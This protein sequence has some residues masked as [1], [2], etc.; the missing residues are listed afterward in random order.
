[1]QATAISLIIPCH[2]EENNVINL[3]NDITKIMKEIGSNYEVIYIDDGS[4]DKTLS[5][6]KE[7][8]IHDK[9]SSAIVLQRN[10]GQTAAMMAGF[11][12]AIGDVI[13]TLDGDGQNDPRDIPKLID[14]IKEGYDVVSGWRKDRKD[15]K[16]IR[17]FPSLVANWLIS[18]ISGVTLKDYGCSLKAYNKEFIK[19]I[20]LYGEMHR[21]IP[22]YTFW[23]GA[24]IIEIEVSHHQRIHGY[25]KYGLN[26][27]YKVILDI[28]LI[29]F[30]DKYLTR[31]IHFF[32]G[33]GLICGCLS[34]LCGL[35]ALWLKIFEGVSFIS[36]PV[37][38]LTLSLILT[39]ISSLMLGLMAE[40]ITRT[41]YES[42]AKKTYIIKDIFNHTREK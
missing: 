38:L 23:E 2:N 40:I 28:F 37:P 17:N 13:I 18:R 31:P 14:K 15:N 30:F 9:F 21:F 4:N 22:I 16:I 36:T 39:S 19:G 34:F 41:Y 20:R 32:G 8:V 26:R 10:Y 42:Q 33:I 1:M 7:I 3:H 6:I 24:K 11:D 5:R 35:W 27:I 29:R 12:R 25:S